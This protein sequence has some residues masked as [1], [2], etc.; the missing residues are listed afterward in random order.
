MAIRSVMVA[1]RL[2]AQGLMILIIIVLINLMQIVVKC[3]ETFNIMMASLW[4]TSIKMKTMS[5]HNKD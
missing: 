2:A 1:Q 3:L 4:V 5:L